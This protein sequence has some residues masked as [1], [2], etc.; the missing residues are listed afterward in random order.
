[1]FLPH[2]S[3]AAHVIELFPLIFRLKQFPATG[4]LGH[5]GPYV[6][7]LVVAESDIGIE[8]VTSN[9]MVTW[10]RT[11]KENRKRLEIAIPLIVNR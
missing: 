5:N 6:R 10:P 8:L 11:A 9:L 4:D 1:M 7:S 3:E 2:N